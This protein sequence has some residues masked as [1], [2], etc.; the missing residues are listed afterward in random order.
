MDIV[1]E[2]WNV[3]AKT[4]LELKTGRLRRTIDPPSCL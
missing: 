1:Y 2:I 4:L 3:K